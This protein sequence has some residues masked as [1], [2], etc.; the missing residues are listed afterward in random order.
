M[1]LPVSAQ[2]SDTTTTEERNTQSWTSTRDLSTNNVNPTRVV[3]SHNQEG[4][5]T[6]DKHSLQRLLD[7]HYE[8]YQD[9]E[10]ES[11][12]VD[13][14]TVR[15]TTRTYG[16][17]VNGA[18][19][20]VQVTEEERHALPD[21][22]SN[23]KRTVS[24]PDVNGKLQ[25]VQ[26]DIVETRSTG[27][28]GEETKTTVML[29]SVDGGLAPAY[30]TNE[31]RK[32]GADNTLESQKTTFMPDGSGT[33]KVVETR[34]ATT[35]EENN[36][37]STEERVSRRDSADKLGEVSRVVT[38]E[39]DGPAGE[40]YR[41]K[42]T[43]SLG[44]PSMTQDGSLHLVERATSEQHSSP[45]GEQVRET[46]VERLNAV[47][48]SSGLHVST[49]TRETVQ[50]GPSG[51]KVTRTIR[52]RDLN[53]VDAVVSVDMTKSDKVTTLHIEAPAGNS[54]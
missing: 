25:S 7:G 26:R 52:Q 37:R 50:P 16:R 49:L 13:A 39:S 15:T 46:K 38:R 5:R 8:P 22:S 51:E 19:A 10:R 54:K 24:N 33:W 34:Q 30:K 23:I 53:G 36:S 29:L 48:V 47:D 11:V 41:T 21:G 3:E 45:T 44:I 1:V 35:K 18:R 32:R 43:Y 40:K 4:N 20:L 28:G 27:G 31:L 12:Q 9:I 2:T 42:E 14:T 17:D 6:V